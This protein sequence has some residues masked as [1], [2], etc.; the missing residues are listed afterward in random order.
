[1]LTCFHFCAQAVD[2]RVKDWKEG[3]FHM[4]LFKSGCTNAPPIAL[5]QALAC[6]AC[7]VLRA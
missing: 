1:M 7:G 3:A 2:K 5:N 4:R 6:V